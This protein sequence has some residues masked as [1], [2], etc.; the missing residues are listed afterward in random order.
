MLQEGRAGVLED[1][2]GLYKMNPTDFC[3][4]HFVSGITRKMIFVVFNDA[5][6]LLTIIF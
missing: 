2:H 6:W 4:F 3:G 1:I 5:Y